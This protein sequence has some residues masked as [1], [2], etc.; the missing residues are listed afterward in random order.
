ML[1]DTHAHLDFDDFDADREEVIQRAREAGVRYII[2]PGADQESSRRAVALAERHQDIFA[3]VGIHPHEASSL[4]EDVWRELRRLAQHPRVVAIGEIG[5]DYYRDLSPRPVQQTA[6]RRQLALAAELGLPII[7]H[8]RDAHEDVLAILQAWRA[9][10]HEQPILFH[11]FSGDLETA[12]RVLKI[13]GYIAIGGPVTFTN[14]RRLPA[15]LPQLP[16][17]RLVVETDCP[18]LAPHPYRGQRNEP[19]YLPL[20]VEKMASLCHR[21][22]EEIARLTTENARRLFRL[23]A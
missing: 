2:N 14:A 15:M 18:Y 1:V 6:F 22:A 8:D 10:G 9:E 16:L 21:P 20:V 17:E 19:A 12:R 23:P 5:L 11:A 7:I 4:T 13:G 3:A